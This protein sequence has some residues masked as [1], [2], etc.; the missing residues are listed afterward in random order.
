[1]NRI[2]ESFSKTKEGEFKNTSMLLKHRFNLNLLRTLRHVDISNE[3]LFLE[4]YKKLTFSQRRKYRR[5]NTI[6]SNYLSQHMGG[7]SKGIGA[8]GLIIIVLIRFARGYVQRFLINNHL[9][10]IAIIVGLIAW[11]VYPLY[12][13]IPT[14]KKTRRE[15]FAISDSVLE[16]YKKGIEY[17]VLNE[18]D[19]ITL[20]N[21]KQLIEKK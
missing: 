18:G 19:N 6:F 20:S 10:Y 4:E 15:N 5:F 11:F 8:L 12:F 17:F 3:K 13:Y 7:A 1:M 2:T 21:F 14:Y 16:N 9:I